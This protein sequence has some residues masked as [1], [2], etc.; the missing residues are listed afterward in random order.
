MGKSLTSFIPRWVWIVFICLNVI[1]FICSALIF[2]DRQMM[3]LNLVSGLSCYLA[4]RLG[5]KLDI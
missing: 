2:A 3:F 1:L 4:L 5:Q